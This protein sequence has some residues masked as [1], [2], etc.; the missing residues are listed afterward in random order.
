MAVVL[1]GASLPL[2]A[3]LHPVYPWL[4]ILKELYLLIGSHSVCS[5]QSLQVI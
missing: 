1:K 3:F 4:N 2:Q 5:E